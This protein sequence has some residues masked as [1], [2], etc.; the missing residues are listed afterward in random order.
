[1]SKIPGVQ[2]I[3]RQG[4]YTIRPHGRAVRDCADPGRREFLRQ[5]VSALGALAALG[6]AVCAAD[7][8]GGTI[9]A[10]DTHVHF[11]D[12]ARPQGVP[13]PPKNLEV[14]YAPHLP[15]GFRKLTKGLGIAGVVVVEA[16]AWVEDNQWV[17]D[18]AKDDPL[19]VGFIGHLVPGQP[20]FAP[21]LKRLGANALFRGLR[22][23]QEMLA[24]GLG[25]G[26][27]E[28]DLKA[29]AERR[30]SMD[31][32]GGVALLP[33]VPKLAKLA[34]DLHIIID[35]L[36][37]R[38]WN[39]DPAA[40]RRA[41]EEIAGLPNVYIKISD[42]ARKENG[43][44]ID[45][46]THYFPVLDLLWDVFGAERTMYG[47]NWPVSDLFAPYTS[48][49]HIAAAWM[50]RKGTVAA[51]KFFWRNSRAAYQWQARGEAAKL[52]GG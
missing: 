26:A 24:K 45:D 47:S 48:V 16:S 27:F 20:E 23:D 7:T 25:Q 22:F 11:Y 46:P 29:L 43:R 49:H 35:H 14:L 3:N 32:V 38:D 10:I 19:I 1:M 40:M 30:L 6:P 36:P 28:S 21:N 37:F 17:L 8:G 50:A 13:W 9:P 52:A 5:G 42:V 31:V 2:K 34:P 15:E 33:E 4:R 51:E 39:A 18:L 41:F 12:P 44:L